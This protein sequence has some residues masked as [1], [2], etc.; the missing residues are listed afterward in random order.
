MLFSPLLRNQ[1]GIAL[2]YLVILFTLLG[3]LVTAGSRVFGSLVTRRKVSDTKMGLER[4][5]QVITAWAVKNGRLPDSGEYPGIF[6]TTP[7]DAW[8]KSIVYVYDS[9]LTAVATGGLCGR[10]GTAIN[11]SGRDV[12]FLIV[13]GGD[14]MGVS[15]TPAASGA[16]SGALNGLKAEDQYQIIT[17]NELQA[18]VGCAGS[19]QGSLR[20]VNNELPHVCKGINYSVTLFGDGGVPPLTYSFSGLPAGLTNSGAVLSGNTTTAKG[21]YP[22]DVTATD[23][24]MPTAHTVQRRYILNVMSSCNSN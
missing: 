24:Q 22:V 18:R 3:V 8:G 14:D 23:S 4:D 13:S 6:G 10:T 17:L 9:N 21:S 16:F 11:H 15:S 7:L 12:A 19:P 1:R 20:I 2:L 5:V